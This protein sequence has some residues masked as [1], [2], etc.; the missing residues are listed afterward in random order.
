MADRWTLPRLLERASSEF[1]DA[2]ALVDGDVRWTFA[3]LVANVR[4]A[5]A[6][7]IADGV[8]PGDRVAV[9]APN[10][11]DWVMAAL[12][13]VSIG[14]VLVPVS[15]RYRSTEAQWIMRKSGASLLITGN[16]FLGNDYLAMLAGADLPLLRS[17]VTLGENWDQYLDWGTDN[18][19]DVRWAAVRP[20]DLCDMF[21]T[22]G[23]TGLAKGVMAAHD[24]TIR[25]TTAWC[26]GVGLERGDRYLLTNPMFHTFGY[27]AG[28]LAG[29]VRGATLISR[30]VFDI[31]EVLDLIERERITVYPG[32]PTVYV[33][34]LD[35]PKRARKD[36]SSLRLAVTGATVV[37]VAL[38]ERMRAELLPNVIV[39]YGLTETCGMVSICDPGSPAEVLSSTVGKP[40]PGVEVMIRQP[41]G[42]VMVRGFTVMRGYFDDEEATREA[43]TE[44]GWLHT[45]DIGTLRPDGNLC[46]TDRLKDM[47]TTGG[48]NVYPAEVEQVIAAIGTVAEVAVIGVP[49]YRLGAVGQAFVVA[50]PGAEPDPE[51][52]IAYCRERLA[53]YKVPASVTV[54]AE[55]PK[56]AAGKVTKTVL[57][58]DSQAR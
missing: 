37:P 43:I 20:G 16:G 52:V 27:K 14:A 46:I 49:D 35:H 48:F 51:G 58:A 4:R 41:E 28:I 8:A 23:T 29:L 11:P 13:A 38:V 2:E 42:E 26:D 19:V 9:W 44:A 40:I 34:M 18:E 45:G 24:Q 5:A 57:R 10:S 1:G 31:D 32:P 47:Y 21:F 12:G 53:G 25:A 22:S 50:R 55:L 7:M 54:V 30:P 6:A 3:D 15:T 36:L 56:N 39:A 17:T 33:S